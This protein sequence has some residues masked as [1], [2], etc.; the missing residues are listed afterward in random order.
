MLEEYSKTTLK[1]FM[2]LYSR[3]SP[4]EVPSDHFIISQNNSFKPGSFGIRPGTSLLIDFLQQVNDIAEWVHGDSPFPVLGIT[5]TGDLLLRT[6]SSV[7]KLYNV[8]GATNFYT[9]NFFNRMFICPTNDSGP[10]GNLL[11]LYTFNDVVAIRECGGSSPM[12]AMTATVNAVG[13]VTSIT[14]AVAP[15]AVNQSGDKNAWF[16][17]NNVFKLDGAYATCTLYGTSSSVNTSNLLNITGFNF[18]MVPKGANILGIEVAVHHRQSSGTSAVADTVVTLLGLPASNKASVV[19]WGSVEET[20]TYGGLADLWGV[21]SIGD[22]DIKSSQFGVQIQA[23]CT[24][25]PGTGAVIG[26]DYVTVTVKYQTAA[27][28]IAAGTYMV[29]LVYQ[30]DTGFYTPPAGSGISQQ[31]VVASDSSNI[32]L[33][34]VPVGPDY[35]VARQVLIALV[36]SEGNVGDYFFIPSEDGGLINDNTSTT[37]TLSFFVTDLVEDAEYLFNIRARIPAGQGINIYA[38]RLTLWGF[39]SPDESIL[40]LSQKGDPETFDETLETIVVNK[41]DGYLTTNTAIL[42]QQLYIW[43][44]VGIYLTFDS[45]DDPVN[46]DVVP[47]DQSL[48]CGFRGLSSTAPTVPKGIYSNLV[49]FTNLTGAY[50]FDGSIIQPEISWKVNDLWQGI[51]TD[52]TPLIDVLN[53]R[54]YFYSGQGNALIADFTEGIS[55]IKWDIWTYV[56]NLRMLNINDLRTSNIV[57]I[58]PSGK[59]IKL[60]SSVQSDYVDGTNVSPINQ[61]AILAGLENEEGAINILAGITTRITGN[62]VVHI[63]AF[64]E[65]QLSNPNDYFSFSDLILTSAPAKEITL[66]SKFMSE[67]IYLK[68]EAQPLNFPPNEANSFFNISRIVAYTSPLYSERPA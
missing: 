44:Q 58:L 54:V 27:G 17:L 24:L 36:D 8:P 68:F 63:T 14:T 16:N 5:P 41:D 21:T 42:N 25:L 45:G 40:R 50:L 28:N 48:G 52:L 26:I 46:W 43:K 67:R 64:A 35:V 62:G 2:G 10:V 20:F 37:T 4:E 56:N 11:M 51:S 1:S 34:N 6:V 7:T 55:K 59:I 3:G 9:V 33:T 12:G 57:H 61:Y 53:K 31:V 39:P 66:Y 29:N 49:A 15:T 18:S 13:G 22:A 60:D 19:N 47:V 32:V 38:S 65:D 23:R 30:T